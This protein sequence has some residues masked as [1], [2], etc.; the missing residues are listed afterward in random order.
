MNQL[1]RAR[2]GAA[3]EIAFFNESNGETA[4]DSVKSDAGAGRPAADHHDV[5]GFAPHAAEIGGSST[6]REFGFTVFHAAAIESQL[7]RPPPTRIS[8]TLVH[9]TR[10]GKGAPG[11][12]LQS[13]E[14]KFGL[15]HS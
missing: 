4:G 6:K 5:E 10:A 7:V 11:E 14:I 8:T 15:H 12:R 9:A 13:G 3:C 2:A 1:G